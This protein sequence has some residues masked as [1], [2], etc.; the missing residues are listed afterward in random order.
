[1]KGKTQLKWLA[2]VVPS[3]SHASRYGNGRGEKGDHHW[4]SRL[5]SMFAMTG[6]EQR[7]AYEQAFAEVNKKGSILIKETGK[8]MP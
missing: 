5:A 8:K 3:V 6:L 2:C 1:M 7:W 4:R